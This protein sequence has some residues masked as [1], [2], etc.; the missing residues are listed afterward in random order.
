MKQIFNAAVICTIALAA[1]TTPFKKAKDGSQYKI[2]SAK[3]GAKV[4]T[5]NFIEMN[6]VAKYKDSILSSSFEDGM[7]QYA[8]YDTTNFPEPFKEIFKS[9]RVGDSIVLKV[10]TDSII[11]KS[12]GQAPPFMKKGNFILQTFKI[13]AVFTSKEQMDSAQKSHIPVAKVKAQKKQ[14]EQ[15]EKD[16]AANK[17]QIDKD[18]KLIADYLAKNNIK[19]TKTKWGTYVAIQTEGAGPQLTATDVASV[20]YTGRTFDSSKVF[21]SN[22]DPKFNHV[23]PYDVPLG[24]MGG[25]IIG[26]VD[27]LLQMKKGTKATV[28][29]PSSLA[30]GKS[31][32]Q[33]EIKPD[34]ILVFDM[35][36]VNATNE[37][38]MMAQQEAMQKQQQEAQQKMM[39]SLQK[40]A[41]PKK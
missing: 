29:I 39:D 3:D 25:I 8:M 2:I 15:V 21:D 24:Q 13:S 1:C 9:I 34:A 38:A 35:E 19:A 40:A 27:A 5:G 31:G 6:T 28:Y 4:L 12:Q 10:S 18:S 14:M 17:D 37:E 30:Y 32:R 20:N 36:V 26:W 33:P 7:P 22:I 11:A 16:L 41:A 23:Q